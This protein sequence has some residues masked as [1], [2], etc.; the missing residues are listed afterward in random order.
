MRSI[1]QQFQIFKSLTSQVF[2]VSGRKRGVIIRM[3]PHYP[4][5]IRHEFEQITLGRMMR[6]DP[7][8]PRAYK[9]QE[10]FRE[11]VKTDPHLR[12]AMRN[13]TLRTTN[14]RYVFR[15]PQGEVDEERTKW[16]RAAWFKKTLKLA[17]QS[18][19]FG[20]S[21][22]WPHKFDPETGHI[23]DVKLIPRGHVS[24][25]HGFILDNVED[26]EG[27]PFDELKEQ[28]WYAELGEDAIGLL[29]TCQFLSLMKR[30]SWGGWEMWEQLFVQPWR[31]VYTHGDETYQKKLAVWMEQMKRMAYAI[32]RKDQ[33]EFKMEETK[34]TD[35][36]QVFDKKIERIDEQNSQLINGQ[37]MTMSDGSSRSQSETH[38][39]TEKEI[40]KDDNDGMVLWATDVI[41]PGMRFFGYD[42][43]KD[44]YIDI[45]EKTI[46][47]EKIEIDRYFLQSGHKLDP[48][49]VR[50]TYGTELIE[51]PAEGEQEGSPAKKF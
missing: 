35:A 41:L 30:H 38:L 47:S 36:Y 13:R 31:V 51:E 17:F 18:H 8:R 24:P 46:P 19:F 25:E 34:K 39:K 28:L 48:E 32:L 9:Q 4:E 5:I 6:T 12:G 7:E 45:E 40:T 50:K 2:K 11:T 20:Y 21:L 49:Y 3:D 37:T 14:K 26:D 42:I 16:L 10:I 43:P 22:V 29:E 33:D 23:L 1:K 44:Y 15:D 27:L